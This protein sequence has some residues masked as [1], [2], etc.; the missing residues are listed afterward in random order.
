[1]LRLE[2][3]RK[4]AVVNGIEPGQVVRIVTTEPV[5]E[6][7]LTVYYRTVEG[8][9]KEQMFFRPGDLS[10]TER[11]KAGNDGV[12]HNKTHYEPTCGEVH[13]QVMMLMNIWRI[14][15]ASWTGQ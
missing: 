11:G 10:L 8:Q 12:S 9:V 2:D 15:P 7:S 3:I 5:G 14:W 6:N 13:A 4:D 1:M